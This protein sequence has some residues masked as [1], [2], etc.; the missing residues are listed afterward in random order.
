MAAIRKPDRAGRRH[1]RAAKPECCCAAVTSLSLSDV[2]AP[3]PPGLSAHRRGGYSAVLGD[4]YTRRRAL[5]AHL[6]DDEQSAADE[7]GRKA[8]K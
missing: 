7:G 3:A 4:V 2:L 5:I 1:S 8:E 6:P